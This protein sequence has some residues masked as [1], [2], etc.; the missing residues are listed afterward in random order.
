MIVFFFFFCTIKNILQFNCSSQDNFFKKIEKMIDFAMVCKSTG[1]E[2]FT[3]ANCDQI[4]PLE[5]TLSSFKVGA[6]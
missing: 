1:L 2:K 3:G 4:G 6:H 5:E